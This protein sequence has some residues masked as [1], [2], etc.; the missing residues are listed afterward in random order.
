M[1]STQERLA[2][3]YHCALGTLPTHWLDQSRKHDVDFAHLSGL[4]LP[5]TCTKFEQASKR[6]MVVGRETRR[7]DVVKPENPYLDLDEYIHR[8]M[9]IQQKYLF[10]HLKAKADRGESFFNFLRKLHQPDGSIGIAWANLF[11]FAWRSG[12]PMSW[13]HFEA[14]KAISKSLLVA[15]LTILKPDIVIFANGA[16]S[17]RIRQEYFPHRGESS[18]CADLGDYREQGIPVSQLWRFRLFSSVQCYRIQHP[19]SVST[20]SRAARRF[21][22]D[23]LLLHSLM[24]P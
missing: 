17:A 5:G 10:E 20:D 3:A 16:S 6:I 19:S 8:A 12:S 7:W 13:R 15:Q 2:S 22:L 18:V 4:F 21:L 1:E 24:S 9:D 14:L 11:S 23:E